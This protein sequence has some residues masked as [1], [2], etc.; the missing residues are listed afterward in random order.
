MNVL[1]FTDVLYGSDEAW[2]NFELIHGIQH[3]SVY[4]AIMALDLLPVYT[5]MFSFP[6]EE[7]AD[8]LLD[9]WRSHQ[10]NA[11]LLGLQLPFDISTVD[12][13]DR[14]Q[15]ETWLSQHSQIHLN[16]NV[17]LGIT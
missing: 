15:Y 10:S 6:R 8:F 17:A 1:L 11:L 13:S 14:L 9:H 3:Q 7:N 2:E 4:Q 12:F 5:D 16:E